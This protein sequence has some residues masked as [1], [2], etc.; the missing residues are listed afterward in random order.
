MI[1][2]NLLI[3]KSRLLQNYNKILKKRTVFSIILELNPDED[4][5]KINPHILGTPIFQRPKYGKKVRKLR[6]QVRYI[7]FQVLKILFY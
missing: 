2:K 6:K 1:I 3:D 7:C 4:L 5:H